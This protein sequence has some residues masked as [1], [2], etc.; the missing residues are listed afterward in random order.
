MADVPLELVAKLNSSDAEAG[1]DRLETGA[2]QTGDAVQKAGAEGSKGLSA[3]AAAAQ[4][5]E[6]EWKGVA[7]AVGA[8]APEM[9]ELQAAAAGAGAAMKNLAAAGESPRALARNAALAQVALDKL[10]EQA[11]LAAKAGKDLGPAFSASLTKA[12]KDIDTA[13]G[14]VGKLK[15][16]M[17]DLKT[18]GDIAAKGIEGV[19]GSA[20]SLEGMLGKLKDT[21][22]P[23]GQK[24][25]DL[26]FGAVA[27][28]A[29]FK[30]GYEAGQMLNKF[31]EE[32]GNY[33]AKAIDATVTFVSGG[34]SEASML[35]ALDGPV[36]KA[37]RAHQDLAKSAQNAASWAKAVGVGFKGST[38]DI[39]AFGNKSAA[40][41][42]ALQTAVK[43]GQSWESVTKANASSI[44]SL[45]EE[46]AKMGIAFKDLPP[47]LQLAA[48][49]L[50]AFS[51]AQKKIVADSDAAARA[52]ES[53]GQK[54][55]TAFASGDLAAFSARYAEA[56][57]AQIAANEKAGASL[58]KMTAAEQAAH[59]LA[60]EALGERKLATESYAKAAITSYAS[61]EAAQ[62][63]AT[64]A[65]QKES[66]D[67]VAAFDAKMKALNEAAVSEEEYSARKQAAYAEM[68]AAL[69]AASAKE[70]EAATTSKNAQAALQESLSLTPEKFKAV[71]TAAGL[72]AEEIEKGKTP[73]D[74]AKTAVEGLAT[75]FAKAASE[76]AKTDMG[77]IDI[78][79]SDIGTAADKAAEKISAVG[80]AVA[81]LGDVG[82]AA[83]NIQR[84]ADA[85]NN[86]ATA[87]SAAAG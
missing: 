19:A 25:A 61:I 75:G 71:G 45:V 11:K 63:K 54:L 36:N 41:S 59:K 50:D 84:L 40:L 24:M 35:R 39:V 12:Q 83:G 85:L 66:A 16:A 38:D 42:L 27:A 46:A 80:A 7:S 51:D 72:Y 48:Q 20:G 26:G 4:K 8:V 44:R 78:K 13:A 9:S 21:A 65:A 14:K 28:A 32:H 37:L 86:V 30:M 15:D 56:I 31:L 3:I 70:A 43:A 57:E 82:A 74:A 6:Q 60:K 5:A 81:K 76:M 2:E 29:A 55:T 49:G 69:E 73:T 79:F 53:L 22:G 62:A 87:S 47:A 23:A 34:E 77:T 64:A 67:A 33:L 1:L 10:E 58:Q 68:T 17:G 18:K 52:A